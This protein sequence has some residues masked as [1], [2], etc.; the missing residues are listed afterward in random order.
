MERK[1]FN[2]VITSVK[3]KLKD[4]HYFVVTGS[5]INEKENNAIVLVNGD[6]TE[7]C[8][9]LVNI[10]LNT[11]DKELTTSATSIITNAVLNLA[12]KNKMFGEQVYET[13]GQVLGK[14][15]KA[16]LIGI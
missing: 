2:E 5:E 1:E 9:E 16:Q 11:P 14:G 6:I 8:G 4:A 3:Q 10:I 13:L 15:K 12:S 7:I